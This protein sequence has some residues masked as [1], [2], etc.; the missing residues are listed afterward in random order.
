MK[1]SNQPAQSVADV[2]GAGSP[3]I[4]T[5]VTLWNAARTYRG[6]NSTV[7]RWIKVARQAGYEGNRRQLIA[8]GQGLTRDPN[9]IVPERGANRPEPDPYTGALESGLP[10]PRPRQSW[11]PR[12]PRS[13]PVPPGPARG[14]AA[15]PPVMPSP[16]P[17]EYRYEPPNRGSIPERGTDSDVESGF[18]QPDRFPIYDP[19]VQT[20][21]PGNFPMPQPVRV[22]LPTVLP[23]I[24][25][26]V[27]GVLG[28]ILYPSRTA[29]DDTIP[30]AEPQPIPKGPPRRPRV[31][32]PQPYGWPLPDWYNYPRVR[33]PRMPGVLWPRTDVP[34]R[35]APW[36][37]PE[38]APSPE[39]ATRPRP[40]PGDRTQPRGDPFPTGRPTPTPVPRTAPP[41]LVPWLLPFLRPGL[42]PA[43]PGARPGVPRPDV[44]NPFGPS[45]LTP[46][47]PRGVDLP[48]QFEQPQ[49]RADRCPPCQCTET[50]Q[51]KRKKDSCTNPISSKR[52]FTR[53]GS[54]FRT[55]TRKLQ[56]Q[57]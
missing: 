31:G 9:E 36:E 1:T 56:C 3:G 44:S 38:P 5:I 22:P 57:V 32:N 43:R 50:Q 29:D 13:Q 27:I 37:Y 4:G 10:F 34:G 51:R 33:R 20:F 30:E 15:A 47:E 40:R 55:I 6:S 2:V 54:R 28:W 39:P 53:G 41:D 24:L 52:T 14:P 21:A 19:T 17:F 16:P 35:P 23:T 18:W 48:Q 42:R 26:T 11:I 45:P 12:P 25:R 8:I 49:F 46:S 7:D